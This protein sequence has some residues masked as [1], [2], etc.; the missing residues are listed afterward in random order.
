MRVSWL[1]SWKDHWLGGSGSPLFKKRK[2]KLTT[3]KRKPMPD[4][5]SPSPPHRRVMHNHTSRLLF[6]H[7]VFIISHFELSA[8][9]P[10]P[11]TT[12]YVLLWPL[13]MIIQT[14]GLVEFDLVRPVSHNILLLSG[15]QP[16]HCQIC[17]FVAWALCLSLCTAF[18]LL[19]ATWQQLIPKLA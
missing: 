7:S 17:L 14:P 6:A 8:S 9:S 1:V 12:L 4:L 3:K 11:P 5:D 16:G 2:R 19:M 15:Q 10:S 18:S 13:I